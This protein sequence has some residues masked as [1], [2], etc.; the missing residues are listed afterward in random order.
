M[1]TV[2]A[3]VHSTDVHSLNQRAFGFKAGETTTFRTTKWHK[4]YSSKIERGLHTGASIEDGVS[5]STA[6]HIYRYTGPRRS[7]PKA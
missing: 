2:A 1:P 5:V 4:L 7:P 3:H 6:K